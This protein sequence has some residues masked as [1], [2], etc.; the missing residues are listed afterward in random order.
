LIIIAKSFSEFAAHTMMLVIIN[1]YVNFMSIGFLVAELVIIDDENWFRVF[2]KSN[3]SV[4]SN[5]NC[6]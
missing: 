2:E 6:T 3:E 5:S 4:Y 1:K